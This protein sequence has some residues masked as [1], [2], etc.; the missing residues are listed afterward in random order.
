[1]ASPIP[2]PLSYESAA[3]LPMCLSTAACGL[4][5]K[6]YLALQYPTVPPKPTGKSLLAW[7]GATSVRSNGIQLA[8]A[9]GYEVI[10]A[11]SPK[12][13]DSVRKLGASQAFDYNS[14]NI[15]DE[16]IDAFKGKTIAGAIACV[17]TEGVLEACADTLLK[18]KGD[19]FIAACMHPSAGEDYRRDQHQVHLWR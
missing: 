10:T 5:Q 12:N 4:F 3:V 6:D 8:V 2:N 14:K 16:L 13:F 19:K 1:M 9:A 15:V 7:G 11:T 17:G 18:S